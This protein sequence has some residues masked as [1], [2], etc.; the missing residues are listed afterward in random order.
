MNGRPT[1]TLRF[2]L[3]VVNILTLIRERRYLLGTV[4]LPRPRTRLRPGPRWGFPDP[5]ECSLCKI[6]NTQLHF[7]RS[8]TWWRRRTTGR[9][10]SLRPIRVVNKSD[11]SAIQTCGGR[12]ELTTLATVDV[13]WRKSRKSAK[14]SGE[15]PYF[16]GY[17]NSLKHTLGHAVGSHCAENQIDDFSRLDTLPAYIFS[18]WLS[19]TL[20]LN[21]SWKTTSF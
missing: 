10:A 17:L 16:W 21:Q 13:P 9:S 15:S 4:C 20:A 14:V 5:L 18:F 7:G 6:W 11:C 12:T 2:P 8:L 19:G 3:E 1:E